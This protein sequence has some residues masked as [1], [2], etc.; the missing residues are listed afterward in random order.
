MQPIKKI[1]GKTHMLSLPDLERYLTN[2][3]TFDESMKKPCTYTPNSQN[4]CVSI[5]G[6]S[7]GNA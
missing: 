5:F 6:G 1:L 2:L 3:N 4:I 7:V